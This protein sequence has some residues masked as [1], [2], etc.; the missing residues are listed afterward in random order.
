LVVRGSKKTPE[1]TVCKTFAE[2]LQ[3][4]AAGEVLVDMPVGL[5]EG[6][7]RGIERA[8]RRVLGPRASSIFTVPARSAVYAADYLEACAKNVVAQGKKISKQAWYLCAKMQEVD[9]LLNEDIRLQQRVFEAHP[10]LLFRLLHGAPLETTKKTREGQAARIQILESKGCKALELVAAVQAHYR[11]SEVAIDD[12]LD[13]A[14]LFWVAV[15]GS[16]PYLSNTKRD[17]QGILINFR[18]PKGAQQPSQA[19]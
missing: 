14:V 15:N 12:V 3:V 6:D 11:K 16:V 7:E 19:F 10:E 4:A 13:A 1:A 17:E 8:A 18:V 5:P 9:K 2:V